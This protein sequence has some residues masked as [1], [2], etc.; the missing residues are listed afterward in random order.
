MIRLEGSVESCID[1]MG[2]G[3]QVSKCNMPSMVEKKMHK[4][5]EKEK[6]R[7]LIGKY[8][9]KALLVHNLQCLWFSVF[10]IIIVTKRVNE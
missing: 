7:D 5:W 6:T 9:K 1:D 3:V 10:K 8:Y 4:L 2:K